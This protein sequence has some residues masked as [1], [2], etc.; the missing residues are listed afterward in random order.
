VSDGYTTKRF[1]FTDD[2]LAHPVVSGNIAVLISDDTTDWPHQAIRIGCDNLMAAIESNLH[3]ACDWSG[4]GSSSTTPFIAR[5]DGEQ[6]IAGA[7]GN[8]SSSQGYEAAHIAAVNPFRDSDGRDINNDFVNG[9][10]S[11]TYTG[12][13][14][15]DLPVKRGT[16]NVEV[17]NSQSGEGPYVVKGSDTGFGSFSDYGAVTTSPHTSTDISP[18]TKISSGSI[19]YELGTY[20]LTFANPVW[21]GEKIRLKYNNPNKETLISLIGTDLLND[22]NPPV[23][24]TGYRNEKISPYQVVVEKLAEAIDITDIEKP[25]EWFIQVQEDDKKSN[26]VFVKRKSRETSPSVVFSYRDGISSLSYKQRLPANTGIAAGEEG[27]RQVFSYGNRPR[28][29]VSK[30]I[31]ITKKFPAE[32]HKEAIIEIFKEYEEINEV[33][34]STNKLPYIGLE[35][36]IDLNVEDDE[37]SGKAVVIGKS[38][39]WSKMGKM[40]IKLKLDRRPVKLSDFIQ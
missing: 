26:V 6:K 10:G 22:T 38:I 4:S 15:T 29:I 36:I 28:G 30:D 20:S 21:N 2:V 37:V 33:S 23:S 31:K 35:S 25:K 3:I 27:G 34:V 9:S 39:G 19:D 11:V 13:I 1:E 18:E 17:N 14:T 8:T 5:I 32:A 24:L 40:S 7:I 16:I 12:T